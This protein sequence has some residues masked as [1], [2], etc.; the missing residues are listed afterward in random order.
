MVIDDNVTQDSRS[1]QFMT[2]VPF[3]YFPH[4]SIPKVDT[5]YLGPVIVYGSHSTRYELQFRG[6]ES[7]GNYVRYYYVYLNQ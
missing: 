6:P 2:L 7:R 5:G 4:D 1:K 3:Y